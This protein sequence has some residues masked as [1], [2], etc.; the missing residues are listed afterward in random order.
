MTEQRTTETETEHLYGADHHYRAETRHEAVGK[1]AIAGRI[2][3]G[4]PWHDRVKPIPDPTQNEPESFDM[5]TYARGYWQVVDLGEDLDKDLF[6]FLADE[7]TI[8]CDACGTGVMYHWYEET[9]IFVI[10]GEEVVCAECVLSLLDDTF[11]S[12]Q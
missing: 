9:Q 6:W 4:E 1:A 12:K 10:I 5:R 7:G 3:A 8:H 2:I 11:P